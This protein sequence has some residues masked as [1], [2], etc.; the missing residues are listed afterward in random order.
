MNQIELAQ[1]LAALHSKGAPLGLYNAWDAGSAKV[2]AQAGAQAIG[3]SSWAMAAAH[4]YEDGE[5]IPFAL[6]EMIIGRIS[7]SVSIPV[8][9]DV[10]GGYSADPHTCA[11]L[12]ARL[13]DVGIAGINIEDRVIDGV[14]LHGIPEQCA[15][16]AAIRSM[17]RARNIPLFI[18]A[19][20]DVFFGS[21]IATQE[22]LATVLA[23]AEAYAAAGASGLFVPGLIDPT[24]IETLCNA[25]TLPINVMVVPG[26]PEPSALAAAGVARISYGPAAYLHAMSAVGLAA[27]SVLR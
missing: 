20:T 7:K 13:L 10:E 1:Q 21:G 26:L 4:G 14:G 5:S 24:M 25:V 27:N 11:T 3:T 8:T 6:V 23:R 2:I 9:V 22:G 19:R 16:I 15:R 12:V 17:A 18:N